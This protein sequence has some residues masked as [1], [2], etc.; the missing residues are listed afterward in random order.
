MISDRS[1]ACYPVID[2]EL[3]YMEPAEQTWRS[4]FVVRVVDLTTGKTYDI[5]PETGH[6][7]CEARQRGLDGNTCKHLSYWLELMMQSH[8][9]LWNYADGKHGAEGHLWRRRAYD[10]RFYS[11]WFYA[12]EEIKRAA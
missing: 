5:L 9:R 7:D 10:A 8:E 1:K 12:H 6:C 3:C 11:E 4:V 2:H